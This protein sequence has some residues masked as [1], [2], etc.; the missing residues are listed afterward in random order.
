MK[1]LN[2]SSGLRFL[3]LLL[4]LGQSQPALAQDPFAFDDSAWK[5][6]DGT[7]PVIETPEEGEDENTAS[8]ETAAAATVVPEPP[9]QVRTTALPG[10][11]TQYDIRIDSTADRAMETSPNLTTNAESLAW[12]DPKQFMLQRESMKLSIQ[13]DENGRRVNIRLPGLPGRKDSPV[14]VGSVTKAIDNYT[15]APKA[16]TATAINPAQPQSCPQD[17][18]L[19]A[20]RKKQLA[21]LDSDRQ[22][23]AALKAAIADL[24]AENELGYMTTVSGSLGKGNLIDKPTDDSLLNTLKN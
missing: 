2:E 10:I 21:A 6:F 8:P 12:Q 23:L 9:P 15:A 11:N 18:T 14:N 13:E 3:G 20:L 7:L 19:V 5:P 22:T 4:L 1:I 17:N 16:K 24:K